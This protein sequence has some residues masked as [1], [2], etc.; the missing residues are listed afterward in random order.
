MSVQDDIDVVREFTTAL[1]AGDVARCLEL[2]SDELIFS[3]PESLPFGGEYLGKDGFKQV[4]RN[5]SREFRVQLATPQISG[6]DTYVAVRVHGTMTSR[7]TGRRMDMQV[8]DLYELRDRKITRVDV[9]YKDPRALTEL[10]REDTAAA[11]TTTDH[12]GGTI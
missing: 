12:R 7:A 5:V 10:C 6:C 9:F 8:V 11:S 3:E 1:G 2:L 4:L